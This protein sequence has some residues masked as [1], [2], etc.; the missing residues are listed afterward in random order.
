MYTYDETHYL[1]VV[2]V[3]V[4]VNEVGER[5]GKEKTR[6]KEIQESKNQLST[7]RI[8]DRI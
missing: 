7:A 6:G 5:W 2:F 1:E 4:V 8:P 3:V